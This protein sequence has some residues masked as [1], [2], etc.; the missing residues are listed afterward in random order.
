MLTSNELN[1]YINHHKVV[2]E[3]LEGLI[4][5]YEEIDERYYYLENIKE[6]ENETIDISLYD[7][8]FNSIIKTV[9]KNMFTHVD[10]YNK[11]IEEA[12]TVKED[13]NLKNKQYKEKQL[14]QKIK[15]AQEFLAKHGQ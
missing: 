1:L 12:E 14:Q 13:R 11:I 9:H 3:I 8:E 10:Q 6:N 4:S 15:E 2:T 7:D 5:A